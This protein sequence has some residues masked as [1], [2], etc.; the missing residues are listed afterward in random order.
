MVNP[1]LRPD[2][3]AVVAEW[4]VDPKDPDVVDPAT[5]R[6]ILRFGPWRKDH[7]GGQLAFDPTLRPDDPDYGLLYI[8][9]GDGGNSAI[10]FGGKVDI[11]RQAQNTALP[12]GKILRIDPLPTTGAGYRVPSDNPFVG[13]PGFLPEIWAYGLRNPERFSWDT[14]GRHAMLIADIGQANI[15]KIDLGRAGANYGWSIFEGRYV[16]DHENE[17][18]LLPPPDTVPPGITF[19]AAEYDHRDGDAVIGGFVYRGKR[20]PAL[21]GKYVFGD[22]VRGSIF[23]VGADAL[24][25]GTDA[26][27]YRLRL[28]Y[29]GKEADM[30]SDIVGN[31]ARADLRFGSDQDG[32]IYVLTKQDGMIRRIAPHGP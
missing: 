15:E 10:N 28:F 30:R 2:H 24:Q 4:S 13:R 1:S 21:V 16:V 6:E 22:I 11:Y 20:V 29:R 3:F 25:S 9:V 5:R 7:G 17:K 19:P 23:Y 32:E 26:P 14:G 18:H 8:S 12:F 27:I 31:G